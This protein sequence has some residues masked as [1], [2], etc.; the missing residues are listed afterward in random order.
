VVSSLNFHIS[1]F[2][3]GS[4]E[5]TEERFLVVFAKGE[6]TLIGDRIKFFSEFNADVL[7]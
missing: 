5:C 7:F 3:N 1:T 6:C 4:G 2:G